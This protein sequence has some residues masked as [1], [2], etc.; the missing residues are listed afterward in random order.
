MVS[1]PFI[2]EIFVVK[3]AQAVNLPIIVL[4]YIM[5]EQGQNNCNKDLNKSPAS[6]SE[7]T[8]VIPLQCFVQSHHVTLA[9]NIFSLSFSPFSNTSATFIISPTAFL[10]N[11]LPSIG[12]SA[13]LFSLFNISHSNISSQDSSL[14]LQPMQILSAYFHFCCILISKVCDLALQISFERC[15]LQCPSTKYAWMAKSSY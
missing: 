8:V 15:F 4:I 13:T 14:F 11:Q 3:S 2:F 1:K 7:H 9:S 10:K 12:L 6:V 5:S